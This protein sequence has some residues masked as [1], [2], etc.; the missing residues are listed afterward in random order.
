[1]NEH[2]RENLRFLL[3][4]DPKVLEDWYDSISDDDRKYAAELLIMFNNELKQ[5]DP[6]AEIEDENFEA[7]SAFLDKFMP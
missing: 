1:M 7:G 2:D 5:L 4:T 3:T 6:S